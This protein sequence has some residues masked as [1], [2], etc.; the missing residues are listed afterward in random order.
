MTD[1]RYNIKRQSHFHQM[2]VLA[3][4]LIALGFHAAMLFGFTVARPEGRPQPQ[5]LATVSV[6]DME[7][8]PPAERAG[9]AKLMRLND[10]SAPTTGGEEAMFTRKGSSALRDFLPAPPRRDQ[11]PPLP[12]PPLEKRFS[13][14]AAPPD[15]AFA[16]SFTL[17]ALAGEALPA[18]RAEDFPFA[19][20]NGDHV[21]LVFP[22]DLA[23]TI[24]EAEGATSRVEFGCIS[25]MLPR[26]RVLE[27]CGD[28]SLDAA[29][30]RLFAEK[31]KNANGTYHATVYWKRKGEG[32]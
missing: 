10:P 4:V 16:P 25:G 15:R 14:N 2:D 12:A 22:A 17:R 6:L 26:V 23:A 8:L 3:A 5:P 19:K 1:P 7:L 28:P 27:S 30:V 9:M 32:R 29:A 21:A 11:A 31:L 18:V 24:A 13:L 20:L